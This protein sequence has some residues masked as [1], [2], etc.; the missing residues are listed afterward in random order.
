MNTKAIA[1]LYLLLGGICS[2]FAQSNQTP[3]ISGKLLDETSK[4]PIEYASVVLYSLPDTTMIT[5]VITTPDGTFA[6]DKIPQGNYLIKTSFVGYETLVK[7]VELKNAPL[8]LSEPLYILPAAYTMDEVVVTGTRSEKQITIEKT[9]VNVAQSMSQVSGNVADILK[10]QSGV[11]MDTEGNIYLRGNK[12]ILVLIDGVPTTATT[13]STIPSSNVDNIEIITNPDVKYDAEGTGGIINIIT[14]RQLNTQGISGHVMLNYG[15][16]DKING[17]LN[18]QFRKGIWGIDLTYNGRYENNKINSDLSRELHTQNTLLEQQI[19]AKQINS[20]HNAQILISA[21]P[22]KTDLFTLNIKTMFPKLVNQQNIFGTQIHNNTNTTTFNRRNEITFTRKV[23]DAAF[24]YK[25]TFEKSR[26]EL[27]LDA[28]FSRTNGDR[29]AQYFIDNIL[30]RKAVGGGAPT[31]AALQV[32]YLKAVSKNGKIESGLKG[33]I[34]GNHFKYDFY[35]LETPTNQWIADLEFSNDLE[36]R[37]HI[38]S[39]YLMYSDSLAKKLFFKIG[40]RL[41]YST[42]KLLQKSINEKID[43]QFWHPFPYLQLKYNI[44]QSQNLALTFNRRITRPTYPQLNPIINVIGHTLYETGNKDLNPETAD[45][46]EINYSL[47][48]QK[49]QLRTGVFFSTTKDYIT[50]ITLLSPPENLILTYVNGKRDNKVGTNIDLNY[51]IN[52]YISLNP[53]FSLFYNQTTGQYNEIDLGTN[54]LAWTGSFKIAVKPE[55]QTEIQMFF[56]YNSPI[57]LPQFKLGQIFYMDMSVKR[58]FLKN[59]LTTSLTV[60]DIFNT[61]KWEIQSDNNIYNLKNHSKNQTRILWIGLAYNFNAYKPDN[62]QQRSSG[63]NDTNII[64]LGQ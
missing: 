23:I 50:Q 51:T 36:H 31:N 15:I 4:E 45:K 46:V 2:V 32:D 5:G 8:Q 22:T 53:V 25:K 28:A 37:E 26:H 55:K 9:Q 12:N 10:N 43:K 34:R 35:N 18:L 63:E 20:T 24:S 59:R 21:T 40:A 44:N 29:P 49:L 41:E 30:V 17:A 62:R 13:L 64:K 33:F 38:Y 47:I 16:Y 7:T 42:S 1:T 3:S 14:K 58:T 61:S 39:A 27:S 48:K 54:G 6:F 57:T 19:A 52:K 60:T 11:N 56:N